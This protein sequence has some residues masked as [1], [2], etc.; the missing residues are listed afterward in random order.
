MHA[1]GVLPIG[2]WLSWLAWVTRSI[3]PSIACHTLF[4]AVSWILARVFTDESIDVTSGEAGS[5]LR[6]ICSGA[7][8]SLAAAPFALL[9][10]ARETQKRFE[11]EG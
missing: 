2:I 10:A 4:N 9:I 8:L 6:L 7:F 5:A 11:S 3:W 1:V